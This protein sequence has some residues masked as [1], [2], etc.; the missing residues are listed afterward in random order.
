MT[1]VTLEHINRHIAHHD[2]VRRTLAAGLQAAEPGEAVS[3]WVEKEDGP[4]ER[5]GWHPSDGR[6]LVLGCG[7]A[8]GGMMEGLIACGFE[9]DGGCIVTK[10]GYAPPGLEVEIR[11]AG[12]PEPDARGLEAAHAIESLAR[13]A[14]RR[15]HVVCLV[16]GG[17]SA[18]MPAPVEG[19][20]LD[21]LRHT[22]RMLVSSGADISAINTVR[23]HV[24]RLK[25]GGLARAIHPASHTTWVLSDVVGN[26]LDVIASGPT[27]PDPTT[28]ADALDVIAELGLQ[29]RLP[30]SVLRRLEAGLR[31]EVS[32]TAKPGEACFE[33]ATAEIVADATTAVDAMNDRLSADVPA[34]HIDHI[35]VVNE[36]LAGESREAARRW[37]QQISTLAQKHRE[38]FW[39]LGAG[40]TEV[41][42]QSGGLGGRCQ[43][44]ALAAALKLEASGGP[45]QV[46]LGI[47]ATDGTDGPSGDKHGIAGA[48]VDAGTPERIRQAGYDPSELLQRHDSFVA[49]REAGDLLTVGPTGTDVT[50]IVCAYVVP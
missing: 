23:K 31:G 14:T 50:D 35:E 45:K 40:E 39:V 37:I 38:P 6:L 28:Y 11:E 7:K 27:V 17:G 10:D 12:H 29:S 22:H 34:D 41:S 44:F 18:L 13:G 46:C 5:P 26:H 43:E 4:T 48:I 2:R 47:L 32:E 25:G 42:V 16:S 8:S 49:L 36:P 9:F 21:A 24:S 19:V 1:D 30:D 3:S 15:D 33:G 20:G